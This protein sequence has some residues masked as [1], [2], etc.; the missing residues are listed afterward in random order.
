MIL[1][2]PV[3]PPQ[4]QT[5]KKFHQEV[6][7][8][9]SIFH[10]YMKDCSFWVFCEVSINTFTFYDL[11]VAAQI[12]IFRNVKHSN[13][14]PS[15]NAFNAKYYVNMMLR[16]TFKICKWKRTQKSFCGNLELFLYAIF[17]DLIAA[18]IDQ[19]FIKALN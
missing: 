5:E 13:N 12:N 17:F 2:L 6:D 1:S 11:K 19:L 18:L 9:L 14:P 4:I 3:F 10:N 15:A 7:A 8:M 16:L